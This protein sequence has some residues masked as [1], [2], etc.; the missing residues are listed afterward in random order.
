LK[1]Q[2]FEIEKASFFDMSR[3]VKMALHYHKDDPKSKEILS[4]PLKSFLYKFF[5]PLYVRLTLTGFKAVISGETAGYI[6]IK[7]RDIS[8]HIWDLVVD[9]R[10]RRMGIGKGLMEYAET[11][12]KNDYQYASLAVMEDNTAAIGLYRKLGYENLQFSPICYQL[13]KPSKRT[14]SSDLVKLEPISGEEAIRCRK[15]HFS[16]VLNVA[17]G[18]SNRATV[19]LLYPLSAKP[20]RRTEY[21]RIL[22]SGEEAGYLS[23]REEEGTKSIFAIIDPKVWHTD[24]E[25]KAIMKT[26]EYG[27]SKA[28]QLKICVMQSYERNLENLLKK[29]NSVAERETP[30]LALIKKLA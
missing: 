8:I 29:T 16:N 10:F 22:A 6:L 4:N 3:I 9:S 2:D 15:K 12:A 18:E 30:R 13:E 11:Y 27:F 23:S 26:I 20:R 5:G 7:K 19:N 28:D 25:E 14:K 21:F 1:S 24:T 17:I